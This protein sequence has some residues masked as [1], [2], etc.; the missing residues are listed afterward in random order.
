MKKRVLY[1][2]GTAT[3]R[4]CSDPRGHLIPGEVYTVSG[5]ED[6]PWQTNYFLEG[7]PGTFNALWFDHYK[8]THFGSV[9]AL[10]EAGISLKIRA[11]NPDTGERET[12]VVTVLTASRIEKHRYFVETYADIYIVRLV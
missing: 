4:K 11:M 10:P 3:Y 7:V 8:P 9:T 1:N 6:L 12:K 5:Q 2:G